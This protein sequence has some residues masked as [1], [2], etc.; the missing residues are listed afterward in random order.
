MMK[1]EPTKN[2]YRIRKDMNSFRER[3]NMKEETTIPEKL[4]SHKGAIVLCER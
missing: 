4:L 2:K 3:V 1:N